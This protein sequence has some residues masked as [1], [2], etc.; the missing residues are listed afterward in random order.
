[1]LNYFI[2]TF[3]FLITLFFYIHIIYHHK[4]SNDLEI[5][6]IKSIHSVNLDDLLDLRQP[7]SIQDEKFKPLDDIDIDE[8]TN[9]FGAFDLKLW[10][11]DT[12]FYM[13][14]NEPNVVLI[15][16]IIP[17]FQ[18]NNNLISMQ[19]ND[20]IKDSS[21]YQKISNVL[22]M[23]KPKIC[24]NT[25][26]DICIMSKYSF[27]PLQY[28]ISHRHYILVT[29]GE[30]KVKLIPPKYSKYLHMENDYLNFIFESPIHP[31]DIQEEYT[32]EFNKI[33]SLDI[34]LHKND[35]IYIPSYWWY[36]LQSNSNISVFVDVEYGT[37]MN[38]LANLYHYGIHYLQKQNIKYDF[39]PK[40][41]TISTILVENT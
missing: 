12:P 4:T 8:L 15:K 29:Q 10:E 21:L 2:F 41:Q 37:Y 38:Y 22:S 28:K 24:S 27:T 6:D 17:L 13:S 20:F 31:W 14:K 23:L 16:D 34:T 11:S 35:I 32:H 36:S 19:N 5:Y 39:L 7:L 3:V 1:M 30:L 26:L 18:K 9:Y 33:M 25:N 40:K